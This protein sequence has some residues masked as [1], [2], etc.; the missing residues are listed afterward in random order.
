VRLEVVQL[1]EVLLPPTLA[2]A[3]EWGH[4]IFLFGQ[5]QPFGL[6]TQFNCAGGGQVLA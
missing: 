4:L 1:L 2:V 3:R 6:C 5:P